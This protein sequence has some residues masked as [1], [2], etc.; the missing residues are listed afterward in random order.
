M[1][2]KLWAMSRT[3]FLSWV[4]D[5]RR[6]VQSTCAQCVYFSAAVDS[7]RTAPGHGS[8]LAEWTSARS[9]TQRVNNILGVGTGTRLNGNNFLKVSDTSLVANTVFDDGAQDKLWGSSGVDWFFA[10]IDGD[11]R[12]LIDRILDGVSN[13]VRTDIIDKWW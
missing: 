5:L 7:Q 1:P 12:G 9:Y 8:H 2:I 10:N 11:N 4:D 13:E 6:R 3:I